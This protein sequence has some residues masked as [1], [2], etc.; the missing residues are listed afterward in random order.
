MNHPN[1]VA[2]VIAGSLGTLTSYL[3]S[4][5]AGVRLSDA[6]TGMIAT[7]YAAAILFVGRRGVKAT[8]TSVWGSVWNGVPKPAPPAPPAS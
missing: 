6:E 5:Y 7:G 3:L 8:A 1:T 4:R 2:A